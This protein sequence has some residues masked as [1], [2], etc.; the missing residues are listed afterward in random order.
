ML[1]K[2][3]RLNWKILKYLYKKKKFE[4]IEKKHQFVWKQIQYANNHLLTPK[5]FVADFLIFERRKKYEIDGVERMN[6]KLNIINMENSKL[7]NFLIIDQKLN[8]KKRIQNSNNILVWK[9]D[10]KNEKLNKLKYIKK[11]EHIHGKR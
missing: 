3:A 4:E 2:T 9:N 7:K 1:S 6:V 8:L 10:I 5:Q 11:R